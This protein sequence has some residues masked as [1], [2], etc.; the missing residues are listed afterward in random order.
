M[1]NFLSRIG[2]CGLNKLGQKAVQCL[3]GGVDLDTGLRAIVRAALSNMDVSI[4]EKLLVGLDPRVQQDIREQ[5]QSEFRN[6]PAPWEVGY[7]PGSKQGFGGETREA[8]FRDNVDS[9]DT[10]IGILESDIEII[11]LTV[12][13][14]I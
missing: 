2:V 8:A 5:V 7:R 6:M 1:K 14:I 9:L 3:L 10:D 12:V 13:W 11:K 4:M